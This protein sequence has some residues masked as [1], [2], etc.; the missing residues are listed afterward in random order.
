MSVA[1]YTAEFYP[2]PIG[3]E[4]ESDFHNEHVVIKKVLKG[5]QAIKNLEEIKKGDILASVQGEALDTLD[6][7]EVMNRLRS[8]KFGLK[9]ILMSTQIILVHSCVT[10]LLMRH[11]RTSPTS[12]TP[13]TKQAT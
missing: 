5:G 13:I 6:F 9:I 12:R 2:G 11:A 1:V 3:L 7:E 10:H 8:A 4:F